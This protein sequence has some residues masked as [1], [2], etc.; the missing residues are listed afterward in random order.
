MVRINKV[1]TKSGDQGKTQL[2]GGD[3]VSKS[4]ERIDCYG[5]IDELNATIGMCIS[6]LDGSGGQDLLVSKLLRIQN[7]LFNVGTQLATPDEQRRKTMPDI[8]E[9]HI[10]RLEEEMDALNEELP[11][12][13][14]FVLPGGSAA[15]AAFH[16]ARTVCRRA[17]RVVVS[18]AETADVDARHMMYLNRLSDALFV[19][20]RYSLFADKKPENLWEPESV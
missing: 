4:S 7:E 13:R 15:S 16:L 10:A 14:S 1:Y 9:A 17:E 2:I 12:L 3:K 20:G 19:F 18:L 11:E 6:G 8:T 5:T